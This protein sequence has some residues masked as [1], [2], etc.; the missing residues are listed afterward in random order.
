MKTPMRGSPDTSTTCLF[1]GFLSCFSAAFLAAGFFPLA[2]FPAD[3]DAAFFTTVFG[4][5]DIAAPF[6]AA[7]FFSVKALPTYYYRFLAGAFL[8]AGAFFLAGF[9]AGLRAAFFF[10][11]AFLFGAAFFLAG[12]LAAFLAAI[13]YL[14]SPCPGVCR[15]LPAVFLD[16]P[17]R[18]VGGAPS[19]R[20]GVG[21]IHRA[22]ARS[23]DVYTGHV[24]VHWREHIINRFKEIILINICLLY[25]SPS[26][27]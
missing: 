19:L 5:A 2:F 3:L 25:T 11:G 10:A 24:G 17:C 13:S 9:L 26:P 23:R 14:L 27:R 20:H 22:H 18:P 7:A 1:A 21:D 4:D 16:S 8:L 15:R 6:A 12:F